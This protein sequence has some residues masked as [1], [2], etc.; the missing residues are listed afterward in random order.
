MGDNLLFSAIPWYDDGIVP[1]VAEVVSEAQL[2]L[3]ETFYD[4][5][6]P[7]A[8]S[9]VRQKG[10]DGS[11]ILDSTESILTEK[12]A[13]L[14]KGS[15]RGFEQIDEIKM[16]LECACPDEVNSSLTERTDN[17]TQL[18]ARF[19]KVGLDAIDMIILSGGHSI[20]Q[21]PLWRNFRAPLQL[22]GTEHYRPIQH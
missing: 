15:L 18:V 16:E 13:L 8:A 4:A 11:A 6:C 12:E 9:I 1:E 20:G 14:N 17:F 22:P 19:A 5:T 3:S 2:R 7:Q 21:V 10:C